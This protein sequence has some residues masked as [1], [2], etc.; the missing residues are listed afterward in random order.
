MG[1]HGEIP[2]L[3]GDRRA[4]LVVGDGSRAGVTAY[5]GKSIDP[6][7]TPPE[8]FALDAYPGFAGGVFVR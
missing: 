7:G 2:G 1:R 4:D 3:D 5:L 8:Q 6:S